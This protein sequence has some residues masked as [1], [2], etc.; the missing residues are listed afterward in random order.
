[1]VDGE[2]VGEDMG[3]TRGLTSGPGLPAEERHEKERGAG[4]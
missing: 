1:V 4:R 3:E 2:R